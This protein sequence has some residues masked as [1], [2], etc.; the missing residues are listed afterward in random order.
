M[1]RACDHRCAGPL[2]AA[3]HSRGLEAADFALEEEAASGLAQSLGL[4]DAVL[5][6]RCRSTG[7]ERLY[8]SGHGSVWLGAFLMDLDHGHFARGAVRRS[9]HRRALQ[10][11]A[12]PHVTA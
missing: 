1:A 9:N 3:L 10:Q 7:E 2:Q 11:P 8:S 6:V 12:A 4:S 5:K